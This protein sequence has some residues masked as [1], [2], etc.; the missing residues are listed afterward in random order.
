MAAEDDRI[1]MSGGTPVPTAGGAAS[2]LEGDLVCKNLLLSREPDKGQTELPPKPDG[3]STKRKWA[4]RPD[5]IADAG[6][7]KVLAA[8]R[9]TAGARNAGGHSPLYEWLWARFDAL[10]AEL[11][12][13]RRPNWR[14]V[15]DALAALA[16][17]GDTSVLDGW[18][19]VPGPETVRQTWWRVRKDKQVTLT[20]GVAGGPSTARPG[21]RRPA[22]PLPAAPAEAGPAHRFGTGVR[23]KAWTPPT[24]NP[25]E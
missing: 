12:P 17:A 2:P 16:A 5:P 23:P 24:D 9:H 10:A 8:A 19:E 4:R 6:L 20:R 3:A 13:P 14:S 1:G 11:T 22:S 18:G 21:P 25:E 7:R 15:A